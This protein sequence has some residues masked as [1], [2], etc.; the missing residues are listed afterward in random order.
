MEKGARSA[1]VTG[2]DSGI[3]RATAVALARDGFDVGITWHSD[4]AGAERTAEEVLATGRDAVAR[5]LDA[6]GDE[7]SRST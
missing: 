5:R 6:T 7:S 2:S 4:E 1:I 3:G